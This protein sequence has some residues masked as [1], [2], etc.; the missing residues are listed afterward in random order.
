MHITR[1]ILI[2]INNDFHYLFSDVKVHTL[3]QKTR[4]CILHACNVYIV[5]SVCRYK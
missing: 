2:I 3:Q 5:T 4:P 1:Q